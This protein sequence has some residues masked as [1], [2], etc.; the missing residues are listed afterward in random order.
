MRLPS[1]ISR[2]EQNT[3]SDDPF[4][5]PEVMQIV[6]P[7]STHPR[8]QFAAHADRWAKAESAAGDGDQKPARRKTHRGCRTAMGVL[9]EQE[10]ETDRCDRQSKTPHS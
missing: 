1:L 3:K 8:W 10:T 7:E 9:D 5:V 2:F 6:E 4:D